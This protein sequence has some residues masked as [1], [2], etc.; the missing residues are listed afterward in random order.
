VG[1]CAERSEEK[2]EKRAERGELNSWPSFFG[3]EGRPCIARGG[4]AEERRER[5]EES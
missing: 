4:C 1:G 5:R 2:G 3:L